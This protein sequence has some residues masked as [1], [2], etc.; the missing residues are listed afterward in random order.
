MLHLHIRNQI[1][2]KLILTNWPQYLYLNFYT[3]IISVFLLYS[4]FTKAFLSPKT[5]NKAI[6]IV[7]TNPIFTISWASANAG[8]TNTYSLATIA[9]MP[10]PTIRR[11]F[12]PIWE[13]FTH[14][15][16]KRKILT[17]TAIHIA[18]I[19]PGIIVRT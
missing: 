11:F 2:K 18:F 16:N 3:S 7:T 5:P 6:K 10:R 4:P 17:H 15:I 12:F 13:Y 1:I 9:I 19:S 8:L 14:K